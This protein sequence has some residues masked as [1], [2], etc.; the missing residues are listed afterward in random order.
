MIKRFGRFG[1]NFF[2]AVQRR[3]GLLQATAIHCKGDL[4]RGVR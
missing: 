4:T 2:K 1:R 3:P